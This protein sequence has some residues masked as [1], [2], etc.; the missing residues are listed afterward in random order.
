MVYGRGGENWQRRTEREVRSYGIVKET[1]STVTPDYRCV[2]GIS[3]RDHAWNN[4][5]RLA[6]SFC[7]RKASDVLWN[8]PWGADCLCAVRVCIFLDAPGVLCGDAQRGLR[9]ERKQ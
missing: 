8:I 4:T 2:R 7:T 5:S 9:R 3:N 6:V 1:N